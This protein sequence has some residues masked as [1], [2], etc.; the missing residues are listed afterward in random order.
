MKKEKIDEVKE[1]INDIIA[2]VE[3]GEEAKES[4]IN[5]VDPTHHKSAVNLLHYLRLR[6]FDI[7]KLQRRLGNLGMSRLARSEAHV[8]ASLKTTLFF[9]KKLL[10]EPA[11]L[12]SHFN[13]SIKQSEK[14]LKQNTKAL[15]GKRPNNRRLRIMVTIPSAAINNYD[16]VEELVANGMNCARINCAH[17]DAEGWKQMINHVQTASVKLN[18]QVM[19]TMDVGGP[20]IRTGEIETHDGVKHFKPNRNELGHVVEPTV[21][22]L[23]SDESLELSS[24]ALPVNYDWLKSLKQGDVIRFKDKRDKAREAVVM[25]VNPESVVIHSDDSAYVETGTILKSDTDE[26]AVGNLTPV[27]KVIYLKRGDQLK[28]YK[29]PIKGSPAS[30]DETGNVTAPAQISCS[31]P[32][33]LEAA[34]KGDPIFFDDGEISGKIQSVE[35]DYV[36]VNITKVKSGGSKLKSD[37]GIN[38]P[39]SNVQISGLTPKDKEDLQFIA[40]NADV[41][42]FSFVQS[43][44]DVM[45]MVQEMDKLGVKETLGVILKIETQKGYDNLSKILLE[46]MKLKKVGVMIARGDLAIETGWEKIGSIQKE[47]L[48]I[49]NAA[50]VPVVWATQV[51]ENL[52][53]KGLPSRSEITDVVNSTKAECVMLNK[54]PHII[55]AI[56][57]LNSIIV[58]IEMFQDKNAPVLPKLKKIMKQ[59]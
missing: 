52:A 23:V 17:D 51:L 35:D 13:L 39:D 45:D 15:L 21:I 3:Q 4:I 48:A 55:E 12:P 7:R 19:I 25:E 36:L 59:G 31:L 20:K 46:A 18:K 49:C 29:T 28:V 33:A 26:S 32:E 58:S 6:S 34:K 57:L 53:K 54:G 40:Q 42:N 8:E 11:E 43:P 41:V 10:D 24:H 5:E 38:L 56:K 27:E 44:Q 16:M 9:L 30:Y 50:H 22:K 47:M 2:A 14:R 1:A 37:K